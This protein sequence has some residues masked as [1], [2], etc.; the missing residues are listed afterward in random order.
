MGLER[1]GI[2]LTGLYIT[3]GDPLLSRERELE[4]H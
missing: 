2:P 1:V 4:S 3:V